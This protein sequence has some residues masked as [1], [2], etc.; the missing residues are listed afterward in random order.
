VIKV[1]AMKTITLS[2]HE[3]LIFAP[4]GAIKSGAALLGAAFFLRAQKNATTLIFYR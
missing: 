2:P 4:S 1:F 3:I